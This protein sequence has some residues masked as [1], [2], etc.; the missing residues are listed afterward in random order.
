MNLKESFRYQNYLDGLFNQACGCL[1]NTK[2]V[3]VTIQEHLRSSANPEATNE[4]T[5]VEVERSYSC[6]NDQ[7][8]DFVS[9]LIDERR[10]VALAIHEAKAAA[11]FASDAEIS[12]N[13]AVQYAAR[14]LSNLGA[15]KPGEKIIRG[16]GYKFNAE[17]NQ[18]PYNYDIKETITLGFD[19]K[20][21]KETAKS[22]YALAD[23]VSADADRFLIETEI[24]HNPK[25]NVNEGFDDAIGRF[26][27]PL[28]F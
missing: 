4:T 9:D 5:V 25:Y 14:T 21:A 27:M 12:V 15:M 6:T 17:G 28:P 2:N 19:Q 18:V 11:Q 8:I 20:K 13:R 16:T 7:L 3:T 23:K 10:R 26:I 22:L 1:A 24:D